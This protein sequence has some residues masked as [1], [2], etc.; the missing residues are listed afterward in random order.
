MVSIVYRLLIILELN[1]KFFL[2]AVSLSLLAGILD[3]LSKW[4]LLLYELPIDIYAETAVV[5][6]PIQFALSVILPFPVMYI[7]SARIAFEVVKSAIV[8][9][10]IGCWIGGVTNFAI[11]TYIL[12]LRMDSFQL[13][14]WVGWSIFRAAFST[15]FFVSLAAILFAYYRKTANK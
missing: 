1:P 15:V 11:G 7:L 13:G 10:F 8:S 14:L 6:P 2:V 12:Y 3:N 9:T 4:L 5:F